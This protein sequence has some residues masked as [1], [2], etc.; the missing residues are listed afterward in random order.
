MQSIVI[1]GAASGVG[2]TTL[3]AHLLSNLPGWGAVKLTVTKEEGICQIIAAPQ[4]IKQEGKDTALFTAKG[5]VKVVWLKASSSL[6][7]E[8]VAE[9][10]PLLQGLPGV[11]WEGN[12][13]LQH[14]RPQLVIF[15]TD[16]RSEMKPSGR[17]ALAQADLLVFNSRERNFNPLEQ[18]STPFFFLDLENRDSIKWLA[19]CQEVQRK[20][21]GAKELQLEERIKA[22]IL[23]SLDENG[24]L[25]CEKAHAIADELGVDRKIVGDV[26]NQMKVKLNKCQLGCF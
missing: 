11:V 19:F 24:K 22:E 15:V 1:T 17:S 3:A 26:L 8:A 20:M 21:G 10:L 18:S 6:V 23:K 2:K 9:A 4:V 7:G 25:S 12:S 16:G 5:A 13:L 14:L